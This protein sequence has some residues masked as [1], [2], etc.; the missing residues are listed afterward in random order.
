MYNNNSNKKVALR[1]TE[2]K[3]MDDKSTDAIKNSYND[4]L[5]F[6]CRELNYAYN[7]AAGYE[8]GHLRKVSTMFKKQWLPWNK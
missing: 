7:V 1:R 5:T 2:G 6:A 3:G 4:Q 8:S